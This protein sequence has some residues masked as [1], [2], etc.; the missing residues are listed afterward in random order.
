[1]TTPQL[2]ATIVAVLLAASR[3]SARLQP[4]WSLLPER[5]RPWAPAVVVLTGTLAGLLSGGIPPEEAAYDVIVAIVAALGLAAPG[6]RPPGTPP[7]PSDGVAGTALL[8]LLLLAGCAPAVS[9]GQD[10]IRTTC[11]TC[12]A[13]R[14]AC[15][16]VSPAPSGSATR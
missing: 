7:G 10:A 6:M 11:A 1:M 13:I 2:I 16:A 12:R 15:D 5:L 4:F 9:L 14:P 3:L 8:V